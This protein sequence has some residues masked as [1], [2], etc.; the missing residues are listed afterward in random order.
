[1][2]PRTRTLEQMEDMHK[3]GQYPGLGVAKRL[4]IMHHL[5]LVNTLLGE[6]R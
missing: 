1:M 4:A 5:E 6:L 3:R 2:L